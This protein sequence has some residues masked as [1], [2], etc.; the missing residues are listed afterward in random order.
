ML[1]RFRKIVHP[2][3]LKMMSR[4]SFTIEVLSPLSYQ[5]GNKIF[6]MNHSSSHDAPIACEVIKE[7]FYVLVGKQPLEILDRLFFWLNG[8]VYIDRKSKHSKKHGFDKMLK[9]LNAGNNILIYP[10][11]TWNIT[12]SKP[13]LPLNWGVIELAL[14]TGVPIIPLIAE[15]YADCCLVKFG[16]PIYLDEKMDKK[17]GIVQLE[18]AMATLKWDIWERFP[19]EERKEQM[20]AEFEMM[21]KQRIAEYPK[22]DLE[23]EQSVIRGQ[24]NDP[25][26][27]WR[28]IARKNNKII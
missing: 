20:K 22:L 4:R 2:L 18:D 10:E 14:K 24:E 3:I 11:G 5:Q 27:V 26:Y 21:I 8:V 19:V 13:M 17:K 28:Y 12:P 7:H 15:Y 25:E 1:D 16:E 23:Y 9:I 6:V